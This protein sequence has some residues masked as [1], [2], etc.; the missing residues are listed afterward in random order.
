MVALGARVGMCMVGVESSEGAGD[1]YS[2]DRNRFPVPAHSLFSAHGS[3]KA[4]LLRWHKRRIGSGTVINQRYSK[5]GLATE[6][7]ATAFG[8][9]LE[10][11]QMHF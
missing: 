2:A 5:T 8:C 9:Y 11:T 1:M 4:R 10:I 3:P 6:C 7:L